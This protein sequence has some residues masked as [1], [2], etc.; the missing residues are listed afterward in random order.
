MKPLNGHVLIKRVDTEE[1]TK[2]GIVLPNI[3]SKTS[4]LKGEVINEGENLPLAVSLNLT[5]SGTPDKAL[6]ELVNL[7]KEG[8]PSSLKKGDI[9]YFQKGSGTDV[10]IED[11]P[12]LLINRV[13]LKMKD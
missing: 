10:I 6:G 4:L 13:H 12:Y 9:V 7:V 8:I 5:V 1:R 3:E 11:K 2:G